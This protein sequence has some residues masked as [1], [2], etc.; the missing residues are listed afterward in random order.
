MIRLPLAVLFGLLFLISG[1]VVGQSNESESVEV[2]T[3][4][5][6]L[7]LLRDQLSDAFAAKD[8]DALVSRLGPEVVLTWQNGSRNVGLAEFREFFEEMF[9]GNQALI[10]EFKSTRLVENAPVVF[11]N[12]AVAWGKSKDDFKLKDGDEFSLESV[13]TATLLKN[14]DG[15]QVVSFHVSTDAFNNPMVTAAKQHLMTFATT[16]TVLGFLLGASLTWFIMSSTRRLTD[17]L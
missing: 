4:D 17:K 3:A 9:S 6:E 7:I 12:A 5:P 14:T 1:D 8:L 10:T 11:G 16:G 13:W 15:W 2:K